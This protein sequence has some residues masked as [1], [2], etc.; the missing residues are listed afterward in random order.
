VK[1]LSTFRHYFL[2]A[3]RQPVV[4]YRENMCTAQPT[5]VRT[6]YYV[7]ASNSVFSNIVSRRLNSQ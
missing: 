2:S 4:T 6:E 1:F 5:A 3:Y 7:I